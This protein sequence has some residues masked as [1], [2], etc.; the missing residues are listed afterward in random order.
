MSALGQK[1]TYAPQQAM[2]ASPP[3]ATR[4]SRPPQTVMSALPPRADMCGAHTQVCFGPIADIST[5]GGAEDG[6]PQSCCR[7]AQA[8]IAILEI[9]G[10][11]GEMR[12]L[13]ERLR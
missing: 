9:G 8:L 3:I 2:S 1:Q 12:N 6:N 13:R 4:K 5:S 10:R 7:F 11:H